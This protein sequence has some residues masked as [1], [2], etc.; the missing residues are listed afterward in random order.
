MEHFKNLNK[1]SNEP[2]ENGNCINPDINVLLDKEITNEF[3]LT[4]VKNLKS[5]KSVWIR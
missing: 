5:K 1:D 4:V 3:F 2:D